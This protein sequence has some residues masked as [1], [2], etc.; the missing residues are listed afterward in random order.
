MKKVL[1]GISLL[2]S[3]TAGVFI[4]S[5]SKPADVSPPSGG[6]TTTT[7]ICYPATIKT[8]GSS[9]DDSV[10]YVRDSKN[11]VTKETHYDFQ[12]NLI[13]TTL[14]TYNSTGYIT[15]A[16][17]S[18]ASH[19]TGFIDFTQ[20]STQMVRK[21][22]QR[23]ITGAFNPTE[24][25]VYN[26]GASRRPT[27][28]TYYKFNGVNPS[29]QYKIDYGNPDS[30]GNITTGKYYDS[31]G[32]QQYNLTF[33]Y[34]ANNNYRRYLPETDIT[35]VTKAT[36]NIEAITFKD[37]SGLGVPQYS[38]TYSYTYTAKKYPDT[39]HDN[40]NVGTFITYDCH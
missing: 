24:Q 36:N 3:V 19:E 16:D 39:I 31:V 6:T 22:Y 20:T 40:A 15:K 10:V 18:D 26:L 38:Q 21:L 28:M 2:L 32:V 4:V 9:S 12:G 37:M 34:D 5:C 8:T 23:D 33:V 14:Y 35:P 25:I 13:Y 27:E 30:K 7:T 17:I 29:L 1:I 11:H